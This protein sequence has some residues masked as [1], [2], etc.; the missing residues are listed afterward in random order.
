MNN[1][2]KESLK[3]LLNLSLTFIS[4]TCQWLTSLLAAT[5]ADFLVNHITDLKL[6]LLGEEKTEHV[7]VLYEWQIMLIKTALYN[8]YL[9]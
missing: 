8:Q 3:Q 2:P 9:Q 1:M 7:F 5:N 4:Q 6:S